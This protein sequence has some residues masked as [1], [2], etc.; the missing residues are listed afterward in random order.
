M[1]YIYLGLFLLISTVGTG[2][3]CCCFSDLTASITAPEDICIPVGQTTASRQI[4]TIPTGGVPP[5]SYSW[6]IDP[7]LANPGNT[8]VA[9]FIMSETTTFTI[10]VTDDDACTFEVE[11]VVTIDNAPDAT[12]SSNEAFAC[13][14][15]GSPATVNLTVYEQQTGGTWYEGDQTGACN[16]TGVVVANPSAVLLTSPVT[17]FTYQLDG[18][19][20]C[21]GVTDCDLLTAYYNINMDQLDLTLVG[22]PCTDATVDVLIGSNP[23]AACFDDYLLF[24]LS[25]GIVNNVNFN[26][27]GLGETEITNG[28][29]Q[30]I[31]LQIP[32]AGLQGALTNVE[33]T[34][35]GNTIGSPSNPCTNESFDI[36]ID[37]TGCCN[38]DIPEVNHADLSYPSAVNS[39]FVDRINVQTC[40]NTIIELWGEGTSSDGEYFVG[41][42]PNNCGP[43]GG[44][45]LTTEVSFADAVAAAEAEAQNTWPTISF[46]ITGSTTFEVISDCGEI[47]DI[48]VG[49]FGYEFDGACT[50]GTVSFDE[51]IFEDP[52]CCN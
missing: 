18:T 5:Y 6:T 38:C 12:L 2:Q 41:D 16:G 4:S 30:T 45:G 37:G 34:L 19:G 15:C 48:S 8:N 44:G 7:P 49:G 52:N 14:N 46:N 50:Q 25:P 40:N 23:N 33:V 21:T 36:D 22:D 42:D 1:K 26:N 11:T 10:V 43:G 3:C 47:V 31:G 20:A 24:D 32:T 39:Y 17:E 28:S 27:L 9:T 13:A 51:V 35:V 29:G